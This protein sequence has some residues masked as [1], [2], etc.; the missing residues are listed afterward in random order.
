MK[1]IWVRDE[2]EDGADCAEDKKGRELLKWERKLKLK[3]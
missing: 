1:S 3:N 2:D